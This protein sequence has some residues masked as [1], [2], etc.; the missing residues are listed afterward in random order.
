M[1]QND[2]EKKRKEQFKKLLENSTPKESKR[3]R[4][5]RREGKRLRKTVERL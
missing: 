1:N 3:I 4:K 2:F 5:A